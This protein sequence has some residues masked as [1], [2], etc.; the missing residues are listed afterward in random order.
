[1]DEEIHLPMHGRGEPHRPFRVLADLWRHALEAVPETIA[2]EDASGA[3]SYRAL[4][5]SAAALATTLAEKGARGR[6]VAIYLPN[7]VDFHVAFLACLL[8]GATP[9]PIN[10][11]YPAPQLRPLLKLAAPRLLLATPP[12]DPAIA[13]LAAEFPDL[14]LI[15][16]HRPEGGAPDLERFPAAALHDP[17]VMLFTGGSTGIPKAVIHSQG[18]IANAV[19]G[20]EFAWPTR[21]RGETWLPIAPMSHI[22]G[23]LTGVLNPV[24]GNAT[25]VVPARFKPDLVLDL[26]ARHR[27]TVFGG[28]PAPIYAAML[29][30]GN[31]GQVDL[32]SLVICPSGG[33]PMPVELA[34]RWKRATGLQ[35]LEGYGMTEMAPITAST[36]TYGFRVGSAGKPLPCVEV[37]IVDPLLG[38]R[39]LP[40]GE[41]GEIRFRAPY[42][43]RGYHDNPAETAATLRGGWI[44]TGDLGH[45]DAEGFLFVTDRKKDMVIVKGFNV[46]PRLIEE[47]ALAHPQIHS[48]GVIGTEDARTGERLVLFAVAAPGLAEADFRAWLEARLAPYMVPAE[49]RFV[50]ALPVTPAAK[51]DRTALRRMAA[52]GE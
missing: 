46:F 44:Y 7:G 4:A 5:A 27:V 36:L 40:T 31:F 35:I 52:E 42:A 43:M 10:A 28:G 13:T 51:L 32:S 50:T 34:E 41:T 45:L 48:V 26:I 22:Y 9:A 6:R 3:L 8:A 1:M 2:I 49:L 38:E 37:E 30:A 14:D 19:R 23:F 39:V 24:Y 18:A 29:A 33:A 20:V 25:I 16:F 15:P 47:T 17:G 21:A 12:V 11:A